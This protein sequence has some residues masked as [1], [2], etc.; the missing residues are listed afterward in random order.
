MQL[1]A[2]TVLGL[3]K[4]LLVVTRGCM[5]HLSS[6]CCTCRHCGDGEGGCWTSPI[7]A[8]STLAATALRGCWIDSFAR[9]DMLCFGA[10]QPLFVLTWG[11]HL[12]TS[13]CRHSQAGISAP[14]SR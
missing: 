2:L 13:S 3:A 12:H 11:W 9:L 4:P 7:A 14:I 5:R 6:D 10:L 1:Q 8:R